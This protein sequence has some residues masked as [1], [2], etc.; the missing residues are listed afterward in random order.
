[1]QSPIDTPR[2]VVT[3]LYYTT[4]HLTEVWRRNHTC[5]LPSFGVC[6][7]YSTRSFGHKKKNAGQR[8]AFR[9]VEPAG[10]LGSPDVFPF[11]AEEASCADG[12]DSCCSCCT[13]VPFCRCSGALCGGNLSR[14][15]EGRG[16]VLGQLVGRSDPTPATPLRAFRIYGNRDVCTGRSGCPNICGWVVRFMFHQTSDLR[17]RLTPC[18]RDRNVLVIAAKFE[19][20]LLSMCTCVCTCVHA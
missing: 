14:D 11:T 13:C 4:C 8:P 17:L 15:G 7:F 12:T 19:G 10:R 3:G 20:D 18:Y 2:K 5:I 6:V 9:E 1:M 16:G